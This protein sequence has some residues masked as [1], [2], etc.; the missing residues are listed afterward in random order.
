MNT[1]SGFQSFQISIKQLEDLLPVIGERADVE[2]VHGEVPLPVRPDLGRRL[3]HLARKRVRGEA[4]REP[5]RR[6]RE[7]DVAHVGAGLDEARHRAAAAELAVVGVRC[8]HERPFHAVD[9]SFRAAGLWRAYCC[10]LGQAGSRQN[11]GDRT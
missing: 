5:A 10:A 11:G 9:H 1:Q 6:D 8:E 3:L 2:V 4:L 7:R